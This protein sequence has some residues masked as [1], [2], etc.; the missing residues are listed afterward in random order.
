MAGEETILQH[1]VLTRFAY[2]FLLV[3]FIVFAVLEKTKLLGEDTKRL[4]ALVAFVLGLIFVSVVYPTLVVSNLVL[5]LTIAMVVVFVAMLLWGF[6]AGTKDGF[7]IPK[8]LKTGLMIV[9]GIAVILAV[10]WATGVGFGPFSYLF[11]QDWSGAF[12][13]NAAFLIAIAV[14]LALVLKGT[15]SK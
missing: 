9:I 5:F 8:G 6:V 3:F 1:W 7:E 11:E 2:P 4:N 10:M 14:A 12:W 13:T 15:S